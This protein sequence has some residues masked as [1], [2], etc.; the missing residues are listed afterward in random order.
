MDF[1]DAIELGDRELVSFVGAG[2]KKT[3]MGRLVR[4]ADR[5]GL[6]AGYTTTTHMPVPSEIPLVL[7]SGDSL[8]SALSFDDGSVAFASERVVDPERAD[9]KVRGFDPETIDGVFADGAVDWLLVKADGAR[10]REFKAPG[11]DEPVVPARSTTVVVVASV[12][13]VG[14]PLDAPVVHRPER[15]AALTDRSIGDRITPDTVGAVLASDAGGLKGIPSGTRVMLVV[16][17]ADTPDRRETARAI[18]RA[19]RSRTDRFDGCLI[20]SFREEFLEAV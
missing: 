18:I 6:V 11:P 1:A 2:G 3:A 10:R 17:K 15:V 7:V 4:R 16:N 20:A 19:A 13:A 9:E 12:A 8:P 14:Q 5:S